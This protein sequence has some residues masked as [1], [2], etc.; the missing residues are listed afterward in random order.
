MKIRILLWNVHGMNDKEKRRV[1]KALLRSNIMDV[2]CLQETNVQE[3]K[4]G[5]VQ[6]LGVS[7]CLEWGALSSRGTAGGVVV[8]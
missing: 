7:R 3:M 1:I 6:S 5:I 2:V 8:L 4:M